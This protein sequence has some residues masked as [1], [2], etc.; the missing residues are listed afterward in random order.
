L[1]LQTFSVH[2]VQNWTD[3]QQIQAYANQLNCSTAN[4]STED[5]AKVW[6]MQLYDGMQISTGSFS[7][8]KCRGQ[9]YNISDAR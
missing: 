1:A 4:K 5:S 6:I 3:L 9:K 8:V 7:S 2:Y